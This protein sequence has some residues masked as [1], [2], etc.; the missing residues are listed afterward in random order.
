VNQEGVF[1]PNEVQEALS[2]AAAVGDDRIQ[3]KTEGR[4][5]PESWTH[6]SAEQRTHW[7]TT[8]LN[9]GKMA[10]CDTFS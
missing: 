8:G 3:Q 4:T 10:A 2:A 9:S 1:E 5:T 7:F 6:G